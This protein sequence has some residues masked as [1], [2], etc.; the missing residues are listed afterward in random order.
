MWME[1]EEEE[2]EDG[3]SE[4]FSLSLSHIYCGEIKYLCNFKQRKVAHKGGQVYQKFIEA[5]DV[6]GK[7]RGIQKQVAVRVWARR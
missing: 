1:E 2:E 4:H 6:I 3:N 7:E 5:E